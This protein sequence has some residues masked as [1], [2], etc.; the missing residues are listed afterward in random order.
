MSSGYSRQSRLIKALYK[1]DRRQRFANDPN[2]EA[3]DRR[4][5]AFAHVLGTSRQVALDPVSLYRLGM[6]LHHAGAY[7]LARDLSRHAIG[8][9][10]NALWLTCAI[11][12][13][14]RLLRG[15]DQLT[16]TQYQIGADGD[17]ELALPLKPSPT[18]HVFKDGSSNCSPPISTPTTI[19]PRN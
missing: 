19:L 17:W 1:S 18:R 16:G 10:P 15:Q 6:I 13:R 8:R 14:Q 11:I 2:L 3:E 12:D 7:R 9:H 4:R 5:Q